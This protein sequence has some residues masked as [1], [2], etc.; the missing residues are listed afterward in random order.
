MQADQKI[1]HPVMHFSEIQENYQSG[2]K[3]GL[4]PP[5]SYLDKSG[6]A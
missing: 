2:M 3:D 4:N 1:W 5:L 6:I